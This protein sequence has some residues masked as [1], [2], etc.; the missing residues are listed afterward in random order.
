M[1]GYPDW[2]EDLMTFPN[3]F[4]ALPLQKERYMSVNIH[5]DTHT[6]VK[7]QYQLTRSANRYICLTLD[8]YLYAKII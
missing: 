6:P 3:N 1:S 7:G 2:K 5:A 8:S 4:L